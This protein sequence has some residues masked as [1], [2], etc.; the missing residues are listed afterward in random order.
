MNLILY[1]ANAILPVFLVI[2]VGVFLNK[3]HFFSETTKTELVKL[4][5]YVGTPCLIFSSIADTNLKESFDPKFILFT[6][7]A[8]LA[9]LAIVI[10]LCSFI[11]DR[12][13][14]GAVI[15]VGYRSN[16]AIAGMPV[17]INLLNE[18]GVSLTAVTL[19]FV[20]ITFNISAITVLSYYGGTSKSPKAVIADVA[21]NPLII[22]TLV[23]LIFAIFSIPVP[24]IAAKSMD[25]LGDIASCLGLIVIG[26]DITLSGLKE[27]KKYILFAA[28]LRNVFAPVFFLTAAILAGFRGNHLMVIAI[29]SSSPAAV[30]CFAMA[31]Q[32]GVNAEISAFGISITSILSLL[33]IFIS[34]YTLKLL[35]LA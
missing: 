14:K 6:V 33:S 19:S 15:Q 21:K 29:M 4:V 32:I 22:S 34:V 3:L 5:F 13:K 12:K 18:A 24:A 2:F 28:F 8:I 35:G 11:K 20:I 1:T 9:N 26:A 30:N 23:G 7:L 10:L 17:A 27:D 31:K 25:T 16:F